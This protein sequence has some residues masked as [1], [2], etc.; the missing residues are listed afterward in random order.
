MLFGCDYYAA[1]GP[2]AEVEVWPH[3][4]E[5]AAALAR[6]LVDRL[7]GALARLLGLDLGLDCQLRQLQGETVHIHRDDRSLVF[8]LRR[9]CYG[10]AGVR[11]RDGRAS[12]VAR[13]VRVVV[14]A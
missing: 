12:L 6:L 4:A 1:V 2:V 5:R 7:G 14:V 13:V 8:L 10:R 9:G 3:P 11:V